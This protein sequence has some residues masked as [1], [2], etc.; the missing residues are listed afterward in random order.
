MAAFLGMRGTGDWPGNERPESWREAILKIW[1]NGSAPLTAMLS[2]M[3]SEVADDSK[4][5]WWTKGLP[6][7]RGA[8]T[9]YENAALS[10]AYDD[11]DDYAAGSTVYAKVTEAVSNEFR[12]NHVVLLRDASDYT[13]DVRARVTSVVQN[14]ASSYIAC[15]LLQDDGDGT[16][17]LSDCDTILIIGSM[18]PEGGTVPQTVS[19]SATE[20]ENYCQKFWNPAEMTAEQLVTRLRTGDPWQE[21]LREVMELHSIEIEKAILFG[22]PTSGTDPVS[23]KPIYSTAGLLYAIQTDAPLN[24]DDYTLNSDAAYSGMTWLQAG[25]RW[26]DTYLELIFRHGENEKMALCGSGSMLGIQRLIKNGSTFNITSQTVSYGIQVVTW[27]TP[28][29]VLHLKTHPLLNQETTNR[30]SMIIFEPSKLIWR[31]MKGMDTHKRKHNIDIHGK[32]ES[33][34]TVAGL[35]WHHAEAFGFL[36]GVGLDNELE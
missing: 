33:W 14:G 32:L 10:D 16:G 18:H 20:H 12:P 23:K 7:Q 24:C 6:T 26:F 13:N 25:E 3:K 35:E 1:P 22:Y 31:Y 36:N 8:T 34:M 9:I 5:H 4:F 2:K 27:T 19:Y 28:F 30:N 21:H 11:S 29:G 15:K 17:D